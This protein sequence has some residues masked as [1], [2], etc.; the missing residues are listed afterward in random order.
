MKIY[1]KK[2]DKGQ[3]SLIGGTKVPKSDLR[4]ECYG[5]VDELNSYLGLIVSM[6][7]PRSKSRV[8][9]NRIQERLFV[10]GS[11][12][13]NDHRVSR[14]K[15]PQLHEEDVVFLEKEIDLMTAKLQELKAFILPGGSRASSW[16]HVARCVCRRAERAV[17]ELSLKDKVD[18]IVIIYLNRLS[19]YL[20][21]LAR[22]LNQ[23]QGIKDIL[24]K[25]AL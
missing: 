16:C 23:A 5:T 25:P 11:L 19:D 15:L 6:I 21:V 2:G 22:A 13:A 24:W 20:F 17:V 10:V 18:T 7:S 4:I 12:L 14:M 8:V 1:T 9:L 3:T